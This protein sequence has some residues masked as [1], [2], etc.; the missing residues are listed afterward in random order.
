MSAD[1]S[2]TEDEDSSRQSK[3]SKKKSSEST[4][5][6][7]RSS[8]S[9][10]HSKESQGV[11]I[12]PDADRSLHE[13]DPGSSTKTKKKKTKRSSKRSDVSVD[14]NLDTSVLLETTDKE[15]LGGGS[16]VQYYKK[17]IEN[18]REVHEL[19][20]KELKRDYQVK[21][22]QL[23]YEVEQ[24]RQRT[25]QNEN[26]KSIYMSS[27][28][29]KVEALKS[30]NE[31][32]REQLQD[33]QSK[34]DMAEKLQGMKHEMEK[35]VGE[36]LGKLRKA[37]LE[38]L[39][40]QQK[41][42]AA[43]LKE[44]NSAHLSELA[45]VK[46]EYSSAVTQS[47]RQTH[48]TSDLATQLAAE[49]EKQTELA[50]EAE[51]SRQLA[52]EKLTK[53]LNLSYEKIRRLEGTVREMEARK[54]ERQ[55]QSSLSP[56]KS[57]PNSRAA[58][59][60][61]M[62]PTKRQPPGSPRV[63][64]RTPGT[65]GAASDRA[66]RSAITDLRSRLSRQDT[67]INQS[68]TEI[69]KLTREKEKLKTTNENKQEALRRKIKQLEDQLGGA[70][71]SGT[72]R[73][74]ARSS[75]A[76]PTASGGNMY[77]SPVVQRAMVGNNKRRGGAP[78]NPAAGLLDSPLVFSKS[79]FP[80]GGMHEPKVGGK[81]PESIQ[82]L[83]GTA[84]KMPKFPSLSF[85]TR[86]KQSLS[87]GQ[88]SETENQ[89]D[90]A[91]ESVTATADNENDVGNESVDHVVAS[92][93]DAAKN[94]RKGSPSLATREAS[95]DTDR[96]ED[97]G[98][99]AAERPKKRS[100]IQLRRQPSLSVQIL[101][102]AKG[103]STTSTAAARSASGSA[104][105]AASRSHSETI[106]DVDED[107]LQNISSSIDYDSSSISVDSAGSGGSRVLG[108][109]GGKPAPVA[110]I[111]KSTTERAAAAAATASKKGPPA[112]ARV[113]RKPGM[114]PTSQGLLHGGG[115]SIAGS[116]TSVIASS[117]GAAAGLEFSPVKKLPSALSTLRFGP[118]KK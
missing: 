67:T 116:R 26:L 48:Q 69:E 1:L 44:L 9:S 5:D 45:D 86:I 15:N 28:E 107:G 80:A 93:L 100:R 2:H 90:A 85:I 117:R 99:A 78:L 73:T 56:Q 14:E 66:L 115:T 37:H 87:V 92:P 47:H 58:T 52:V 12:L 89:N 70:A 84:I 88:P 7:K 13:S 110:S 94:K 36:E 17:L 95:V 29:S 42:H 21:R 63:G 98:T 33:E 23:V 64:A 106:G 38:E 35:Q 101:P 31:A 11:N 65:A 103:G 43:S 3:K 34:E 30:Q 77:T 10:R 83:D 79:G 91:L 102:A 112:G 82:G 46:K 61:Y 19:K 50:E 96:E 4:S 27:M 108:T 54:D 24:L 57:G 8:K 118:Q 20:V 39:E 114:P 18:E 109:R 16:T 55:R 22:E 76:A 41:S 25:L 49:L 62:S 113:P 81:Q 32:L 97:A 111:F 104:A 72:T 40:A 6:D 75:S 68:K 51:E 59:P 71:E 60:S 74:R 105:G 53:E